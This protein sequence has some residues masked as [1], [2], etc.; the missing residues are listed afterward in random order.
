[1][2][3]NPEINADWNHKWNTNL[4]FEIY[5]SGS[6]GTPK[7][8][9]LWP[10][11]LKWSAEQTRKHFIKSDN[12]HQLISLPIDKAGGFMQWA[13]AKTWNSEFD[14][15]A[16]SSNPLLEYSGKAKVSSFTPMQLEGIL[17]NPISKEKLKEFKSILI[18]G[19]PISV[20][21]E[22]QLLK[23]Y[24]NIYWVHTFG[25]TETY[26]HFAGRTLGEN[27][28]RLIDD[29]RIDDSP[30]GMRIKNP[31][32]HDQWVQTF[33]RISVLS[34]N[35]FTWIGRTDFTI[36]SGGIK[37]QLETVEQEIHEQTN[38]PLSDFFCWYE[39]DAVLGQKLVLFIK[40][41]LG[42][43]PAL[44][45]SSKYFQPKHVHIKESFV[46]STSGK[47]LRAESSS[48]MTD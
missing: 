34:E 37:I 7:P 30:L 25:M 22:A 28:Y 10:Q 11:L 1:M 48:I 8:H 14:L 41:N 17:S 40:S 2:L 43:V 31:C 19:A 4:P 21:M 24:P 32:T 6:T 18:G 23:E 3:G 45:F 5:T 20:K 33:D 9:Q 47:I 12:L 42:Q 35:R 13:R 26:S 38:W 16:P 15:C 29:T 27:E 39:N 44:H 46:Y 36:N